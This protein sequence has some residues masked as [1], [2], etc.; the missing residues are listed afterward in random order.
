M[1]YENVIVTV[2]TGGY[3]KNFGNEV[4]SMLV[5]FVVQSPTSRGE[6]SPNIK[7]CKQILKAEG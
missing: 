6:E 5:S 2:L 4:T 1:I 3:N 7:R